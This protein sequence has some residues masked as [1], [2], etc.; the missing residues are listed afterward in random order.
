M[1]MLFC[2]RI[3]LLVLLRASSVSSNVL[4]V[5]NLRLLLIGSR[6]SQAVLSTHRIFTYVTVQLN[7]VFIKQAFASVFETFR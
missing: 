4:W 2:K 7:A 6:I 3:N 1:V 5:R